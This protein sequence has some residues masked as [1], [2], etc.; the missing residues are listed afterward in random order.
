MTIVHWGPKY[1]GVT[2][3]ER[4]T[5]DYDPEEVGGNALVQFGTELALPSAI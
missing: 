1:P 2:Y 5:K 3:N 4:K